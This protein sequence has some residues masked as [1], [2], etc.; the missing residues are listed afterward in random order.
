MKRAA[1]RGEPSYRYSAGSYK[2]GL[3]AAGY[4]ARRRA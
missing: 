4:N 3:I 2:A 1:G